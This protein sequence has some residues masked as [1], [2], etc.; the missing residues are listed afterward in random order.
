MERIDN[1][2]N[3]IKMELWYSWLRP[4]V[5]STCNCHQDLH[6]NSENS[7]ISLKHKTSFWHSLALSFYVRLGFVDVLSFQSIKLETFNHT[8]KQYQTR[9]LERNRDSNLDS[10]GLSIGVREQS[11]LCFGDSPNSQLLCKLSSKHHTNND[12]TTLQRVITVFLYY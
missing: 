7:N 12:C 11:V 6:T 8:R 5:A 9:K 4:N 1:E 2:K 3:K 10:K